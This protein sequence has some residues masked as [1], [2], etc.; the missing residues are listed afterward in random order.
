MS[1][2]A[3][4]STA[5]IVTMTI[6]LRRSRAF[7][8]LRDGR[9]TCGDGGCCQFDCGRPH[10]GGD[11]LGDGAGAGGGVTGPGVNDDRGC[12]VDGRGCDVDGDGGCAGGRDADAC[13]GGGAHSVSTSVRDS[14]RRSSST[15]VTSASGGPRTCGSMTVSAASSR[16][17]SSAGWAAPDPCPD[18]EPEPGGRKRLDGW[19]VTVSSVSVRGGD[20]TDGR[21]GGVPCDGG[22]TCDPGPAFDGGGALRERP[23]LR[24]RPRLRR[25]RRPAHRP[26]AD[27]PGCAPGPAPAPPAT[28]REGPDGTAVRPSDAVRAAGRADGA[29]ASSRPA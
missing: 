7:G 27:G 24:G 20:E 22:P 15:S 1:T 8:V 9:D 26:P 17:S 5:A 13:G 14:L 3:I 10:G 2:A 29:P 25:R 19:S 4:T 23:G 12:D 28:A 18:P 21:D 6:V 16:V 11:W